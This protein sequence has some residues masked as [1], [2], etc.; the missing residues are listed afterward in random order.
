MRY[1]IELLI[2]VFVL[3]VFVQAQ[4]GG[5]KN[6]KPNIVIINIDNHSK[7]MLGCYGNT[8]IETPNIDKLYETAVRFDN[9]H[10][11]SRCSASRS[12][13]LSGQ[14]HQRLGSIGTGDARV[15]AKAGVT[16]MPEIFNRAGYE[17]ALFGKWHI[18]ENYPYRP[19]D[20][21]FKEV[22]AKGGIERRDKIGKLATEHSYRHNGKWENY[23]GYRTDIWFQELHRYI[24]EKKDSP[25]VAY[26]A[27]WS[28]HY[29]NYGPP[30]LFEKFKNKRD[31][32]H[33]NIGFNDKTK[34]NI[35][36]L[37]AEMECIDTHIGETISLLKELNLYDNTI[38][39]YMSDGKGTKSPKEINP[40]KIEGSYIPLII[41]WPNGNLKNGISENTV[42]ANIDVLPTLLDMCGISVSEDVRFDG[43][44]MI[45]LIKE[46]DKKWEPRTYIY[47][48]QSRRSSRVVGMLPLDYTIVYTPERTVAWSKGQLKTKDASP[49]VIQHAKREWEKWWDSV[50]EDYPLCNYVIVGT[51]HE[52]PTLIVDT[53]T[54]KDGFAGK[55]EKYYFAIEFSGN[56]KY[57]FSTTDNRTGFLLIDG[58]KYSGTFPMTLEMA[59]GK[60]LILVNTG[61]DKGDKLL[62][63]EK[64]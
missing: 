17:T 25:F 13:L 47:D 39:I 51:P 33:L 21:G 63:I 7:S 18:G 45:S 24:K 53:Y 38:F 15:I 36:N 9:Y 14:Y 34:D 8:F 26:L 2:A 32:L 55:G 29:P 41:N 6:C 10:C 31:S 11:A 5:N 4:K 50:T 12:A 27:T 43:Q 64:M 61:N 35:L 49:E 22:V 59:A 20:R 1:K 42:V 60:S 28:T 16:L 30:E 52:N 58:K 23:E 56:G 3:S 54:I 48:H 57:K 44:S 46:S 40:N 62:K 19:E 37:A